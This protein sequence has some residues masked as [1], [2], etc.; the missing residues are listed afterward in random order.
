M[1]SF[2]NSVTVKVHQLRHDNVGI[3]PVLSLE[4]LHVERDP[5]TSCFNL[6]MPPEPPKKDT[7]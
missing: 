3:E 7:P 2:K 5:L 4:P 6:V 1:L